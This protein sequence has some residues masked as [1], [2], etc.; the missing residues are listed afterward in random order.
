MSSAKGSLHF[1]WRHGA[2][3]PQPEKPALSSKTPP[4]PPALTRFD[5][6]TADAEIAGGAITLKRNE[7]LQGFRKQAVEAALTLGDPPKV[8]FA[9]PKEA[10]AKR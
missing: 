10:Q 7:V 5:R 8:A 4:I 2:I 3:G 9:A 6:W 1:E